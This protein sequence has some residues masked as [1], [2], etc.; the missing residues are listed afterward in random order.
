[1]G[2]HPLETEDDGR[3]SAAPLR[4]E[5]AHAHQSGVGGNPRRWCRAT[6][7]DDARH[8]R[9]VPSGVAL[10]GVSRIDQV[11]PSLHSRAK[12]GVVVVD[13]R[14]EHGDRHLL[15]GVA[16]LPGVRRANRL[17]ED[18]WRRAAWRGVS[19]AD[20]GGFDLAIDVDAADRRVGRQRADL[21]WR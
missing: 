17:L 2:D 19:G 9:T 7:G 8:V 21:G 15:A 12:G 20:G 11:D 6:G 14:V 16:S 1:M 4:I 3:E 18:D 13:A 5:N 10:G